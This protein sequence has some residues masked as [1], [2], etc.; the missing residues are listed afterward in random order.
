MILYWDS[1]LEA[2]SREKTIEKIRE[3]SIERKFKKFEEERKK[4][5]QRK[6]EIAFLREKYGISEEEYYPSLY[7]PIEEIET[8]MALM[9]IELRKD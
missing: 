1:R 9:T 5:E 3:I 8:K 4:Q 6:N 2:A 7:E